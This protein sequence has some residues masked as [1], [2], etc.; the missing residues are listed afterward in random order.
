DQGAGCELAV[1]GRV[2]LARGRLADAEVALA[3]IGV[4]GAQGDAG[5]DD[6][7]RQSV[8]DQADA[9]E[10]AVV[11]AVEDAL[12]DRGAV[13][14]GVDP[15][16]AEEDAIGPGHRLF[17]QADRGGAVDAVGEDAE[18]AANRLRARPGAAVDLDPGEAEAR[19]LLEQARRY[20]ALPG[21]R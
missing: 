10:G 18:A 11:K 4:E 7:N 21:G 13:V 20:P 1:T 17:A 5:L 15:D 3:T 8:G 12:L 16:L 14:V 6:R 9:L 2:G 19:E